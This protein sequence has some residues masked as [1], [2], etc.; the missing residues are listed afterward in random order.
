MPHKLFSAQQQNTLLRTY[1]SLWNSLAHS[2]SPYS[3]SKTKKCPTKPFRLCLHYFL[4]YISSCFPSLPP[5]PSSSV[6]PKHTSQ[7]LDTPGNYHLRAVRVAD[8]RYLHNHA[9]TAF[10]ISSDLSLKAVSF[11]TVPCLPTARSY[12]FPIAITIF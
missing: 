12:V 8:H 6:H 10:S 3:E 11:K 2:F 7:F 9:I 4:D 5:T 1:K